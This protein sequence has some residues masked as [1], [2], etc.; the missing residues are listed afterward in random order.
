MNNQVEILEEESLEQI[1][2]GFLP[3]WL[4]GVVA[5]VGVYSAA[6]TIYKAAKDFKSG[7]DSA[8]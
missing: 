2:G 8:A 3:V 4:V 1:Q 6:D 5:V 7:W